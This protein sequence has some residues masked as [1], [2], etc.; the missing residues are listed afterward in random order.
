MTATKSV[1]A[2]RRG[3]WRRTLQSCRICC[4]DRRVGALRSR[5]RNGCAIFLRKWNLRMKRA[6]TMLEELVRHVRPPRGCAI[7][8]AECD[9]PGQPM[10]TGSR[11]AAIWN[12]KSSFV[13]VK[14]SPNGAGKT[15]KSTGQTL[16]FLPVNV[17]WSFGFERWTAKESRARRYCRQPPPLLSF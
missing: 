1:S 3:G 15:H 14:K 10:Q 17:A 12:C 13:T 4:G 7:V 16:R 8:L 9:R 6:E 2:T 5:R 11:H